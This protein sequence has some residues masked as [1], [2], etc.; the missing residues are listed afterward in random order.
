MNILIPHKWLLEHLDTK[1]NPTEIQKQLSLCGPSV[2]RIYERQGDSVYDIEVTTNRVDA[3]SVRGIAREAAVIL[4]N[5]GFPSQLKTLH[6]AELTATKPELPLPKID[7]TL[8]LCDRILAVVLD[9][10]HHGE[11]P[12]DLTTKLEQVDLNTK[13]EIIDITNAVAHELGHPC[14]AFDYDKIMKLGGTIRV[15][16]ASAGMLFTTLDGAQ[17]TTVGGEIVFVNG[18]GEIIDLPSI[19]GTLNTAVD[20]HTKRVLLW[21]ES[22]SA[23]KVRFASMT[24]GIR[25]PA[26]QLNERDLDH[27]LGKEVILRAAQLAQ[28]LAGARVASPLFDQ[29]SL[30]SAPQPIFLPSS[31]ITRYL[32][33]ELPGNQ[34]TTILTQLGCTVEISDTGWEVTPPN[35]RTDLE[36][37]ADLVEE[38]ARIYGYHRLPSRILSG[39]IPT[40]YPTDTNFAAEELV[41][42]TL[43][44]LGYQEQL[45]YSLVPVAK[46]QSAASKQ[47]HLKNA[48]T[49]DKEALR[50]SLVP[51]HLEVMN[52]QWGI[53]TLRGTF[54]LANVYTPQA[55]DLPD[56]HLVLAITDRDIRALRSSLEVLWN[57]LFISSDSLKIQSK[58]HKKHEYISSIFK[59]SAI[60]THK[61]RVLGLIGVLHN[62]NAAV[63]LEWREVLAIT[64]RWPQYQPLPKTSALIEDWTISKPE[65]IPI[66]EVIQRIRA[67]DP[68]IRTVILK[69]QYK[70]NWT[71]TVVMHDREVQL[72]A[73]QARLIREKMG[74]VGPAKI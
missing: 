2:E 31:E 12:Q 43:A 34:V 63:E 55:N 15:I 59:S 61:Q 58:T 66:E 46:D 41:A 11:S 44:D 9:N 21:V 73:E 7:N 71:F 74:R 38:V 47:I 48:L 8:D 49:Q 45:T 65:G 53:T 4:T 24:H 69:D 50:R 5:A 19:M 33:L 28:E 70:N 60:I 23:D 42:Q 54:E 62:G 13:D 51:S 30:P 17:Y 26:A 25:T 20:Q 1:A 6:L 72:D 57:R 36:I 22:I 37:P 67:V 68:R 16:E 52:S 18:E 56:E 35:F 39:S 40:I 10:V 3:M 32:G 14:H 27:T 64:K 29:I